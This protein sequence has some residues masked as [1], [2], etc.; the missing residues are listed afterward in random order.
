M[1]AW[2]TTLAW[3]CLRVLGA[4]P[5]PLELGSAS[6]RVGSV[7]FQAPVVLLNLFSAALLQARH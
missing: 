3:P 1:V 6:S 7:G 5:E 4:L 2:V